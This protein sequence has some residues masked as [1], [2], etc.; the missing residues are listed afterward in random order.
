[1]TK[2]DLMTGVSTD[3]PAQDAQ[4]GATTPRAS[5]TPRDRRLRSLFCRFHA[6]GI[7]QRAPTYHRS[8]HGVPTASLSLLT[9]EDRE[10]DLLVF[11]KDER[12][13]RHRLSGLQPGAR[14]YAEG[15]VQAPHVAQ[16]EQIGR[17]SCRERV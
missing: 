4:A 5:T 11:D 3:A 9:D 10:L 13:L 15:D 8:R 1:M 14:A 12:R 2:E 17:A 7:V 16:R 6:V